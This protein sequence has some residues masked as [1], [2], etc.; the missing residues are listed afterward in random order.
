LSSRGEDNSDDDGT[1]LLDVAVSEICAKLELVASVD[2]FF[3]M[4]FLRA[5]HG[6]STAHFGCLAYLYGLTGL[7]GRAEAVAVD[8]RACVAAVVADVNIAFLHLVLANCAAEGKLEKK[9]PLL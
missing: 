4:F 7:A 6:L 3:F 5:K 1:L 2:L 8:E 9:V